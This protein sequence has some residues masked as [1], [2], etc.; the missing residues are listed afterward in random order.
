MMKGFVLSGLA[1]I[2]LIAASLTANAGDFS[3]Y[4]GPGGM[5]ITGEAKAPLEWSR[6]KNVKW[7]AELPGPGNSS[8]IVSN[9]K[10]FVTCATDE[11]RKRSLFCFD[12]A[13][14]KEIWKRTVAFGEVMPTHKTNPYS[15]SSPVSNGKV[16]VVWHGSAGL[17][18]YD[19]GGEEL[20]SK[21][22]GE[23]RHM[24][25][26]AGSPV[27][28]GDKVFL[29][30][31]PGKRVFLAAISLATGKTLWETDEEVYGSGERNSENH[32]TG[33]WST[34]VVAEIDGKEQVI[35]SMM[36]RV[37]GYDP[38]TGEIIWT[39]DG[40]KGV[41]GELAYSSPMIAGDVCVQVGGFGGPAIGFELGGKGNITKKQRLWR[42]DRNPQSIGSGVFVDGHLYI[43]DAAQGTICCMDPKTGKESWREKSEGPNFWGSIVEAAGRL[44]VTNQRGDTVV[45][46]P[47][48]EKL[49]VLAV[50]KLGEQSN[51]TPA[52][53]DGDIFLRTFKAVYCIS[54]N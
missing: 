22:L 11:G 52:I 28:H 24:W 41:K 3:Q 45:I 10:V 43:P 5:G 50:N 47:N 21:D 39:C 19:I 46:V 44:Y 4:R 25:G 36:T 34:P 40:I 12:R 54:E 27:I 9:G 29:N 13:T 8:P 23:F 18:C 1:A 6:E 16:V 26:Y 37:N 42:N 7:R 53:S 14:G 15:A 31:G 32:Y 49:E 30:C 20:W 35:C 2:V 17:K 51:S 48:P 38:E 33:S